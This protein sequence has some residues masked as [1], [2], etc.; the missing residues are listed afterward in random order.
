[1][2]TELKEQ[3]R[4]RAKMFTGSAIG[5]WHDEDDDADADGDDGDDSD[6]M[7]TMKM[8]T[9]MKTMEM[10]KM[11]KMMKMRDQRLIDQEY[12]KSYPHQPL[13]SHLVQICHQHLHFE[14]PKQTLP[15]L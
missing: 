15:R 7:T 6:D 10:M 1:M 12:Q 2:K 3:D 11:M 5:Q 13:K 8:M 4:A 9:M 14:N